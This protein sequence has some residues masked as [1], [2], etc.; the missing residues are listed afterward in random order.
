MGVE[1]EGKCVGGVLRDSGWAWV[2][3]RCGWSVRTCVWSGV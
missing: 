3:G 2:E 1:C